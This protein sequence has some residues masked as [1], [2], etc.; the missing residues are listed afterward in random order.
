MPPEKDQSRKHTSNYDFD[1]S[2]AEIMGALG[3]IKK[4]IPNG[5]LKVLQERIASMDEFQQELKEDLRDIKKM[6]M[7]PETGLIVKVNKATETI[8]KNEEYFENVV[9]Q[10]METISHLESWKDGVTKLLW[11]LASGLVSIVL[12]LIFN[13]K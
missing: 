2:I 4:N 1:Q 13:S 9:K 6:L 10:K 7:D 11:I 12:G 5:E 3:E 8:K